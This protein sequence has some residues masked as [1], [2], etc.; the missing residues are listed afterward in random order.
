MWAA[1]PLL[2]VVAVDDLRHRRIRNRDVGALA[3]VT[4]V[5]VAAFAIDQGGDVVGRAM[6]GATLA[7]VPLLVAA[8]MGPGRMGGGDV[9]LAAVI[10]AL[11]GPVSPWLSLAAVAG[12]LV[13][14]LVG[15]TMR[16]ARHAPLAPALAV[17]AV[18]ALLLS[19][20]L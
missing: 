12:A 10:G 11:L 15:M 2:A 1:A 19:A 6:L 9:K 7:A 20:G 3:V 8:V 16:M 18:T 4:A 5:V 17:S 14:T 13:L